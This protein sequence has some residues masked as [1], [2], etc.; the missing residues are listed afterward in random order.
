MNTQ[1]LTFYS[2]QLSSP[3]KGRILA[4]AINLILLLF[5][6][7]KLEM[8]VCA[9]DASS[10]TNSEHRFTRDKPSLAVSAAPFTTNAISDLVPKSW[11]IE[12][13]KQK[14][15]ERW[16]AFAI[17]TPIPCSDTE[18]KLIYY[19]VPV[20]IGTNHFP[21]LLTPPAASDISSDDLRSGEL[22]GAADY[23]TFDVSARRS[24]YPIPHYGGGLPP[25]LVTYH[26]AVEV[27]QTKLNDSHLKLAHYYVIGPT[28]EY[29]D[30]VTPS[31]GRVLIN[32]RNLRCHEIP[33][34]VNPFATSDVATTNAASSISIDEREN[35][36]RDYQRQAREEWDKIGAN[37]Q[38]GN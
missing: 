17:G 13:V 14:A 16:A 8:S 2:G 37:I 18:G 32:A 12:A 36:K 10:K 11:V 30:F 9:N 26:K 19:H 27:A 38:K 31:G 29:Y 34:G 7:T 33:S 15:S 1:Y 25:F 6:C 4:N 28:E 5:F 21:E 3:F 20:A 24:Y 35:L 22:W 23:W